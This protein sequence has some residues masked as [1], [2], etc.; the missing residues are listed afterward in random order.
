MRFWDSS[1]LVPLCLSDEATPAIVLLLEADA[2]TALWWA[3]PVECAS[4]FARQRRE[5]RLSPEAERQAGDVLDRL[6]S[7]AYAVDPSPQIQEVAM[8]VVRV[9]PLSSVDALQ[10]AAALAWADGAPAGREFVCLDRRLREAAL[11]EG[12]PVL[13]EE[14]PQL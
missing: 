4:A 2:D 10:L 7:S 12:F 8:R 14:P 9:H 11:R 13:P 1:A 3:T 5:G 6:R